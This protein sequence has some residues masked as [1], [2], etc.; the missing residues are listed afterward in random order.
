MNILIQPRA[1]KE[2]KA[3]PKDAIEQILRKLYSIK[4]DPLRHI[5]RLKGHS[6]WK[7]R[8]GDYRAILFAET[9]TDTLHVVKIGHRK[10][11]YKRL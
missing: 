8:I 5:E 2:L 7:L 6:L 10:N 1:K 4:D 11:I 9:K 3:L